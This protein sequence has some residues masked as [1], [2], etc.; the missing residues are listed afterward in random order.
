MKNFWLRLLI[1]LGV[2]YL[3]FVGE[4]SLFQVV[5]FNHKIRSLNREISQQQETTTR[6]R[7]EIKRLKF[8]PAYLEKIAREQY[9]MAKSGE[10]IFWIQPGD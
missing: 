8:D 3:F 7:E 4:S 6:L 2:G 9:R 10:T 5:K 1:L